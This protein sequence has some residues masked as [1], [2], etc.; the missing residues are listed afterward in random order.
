MHKPIL[1]EDLLKQSKHNKKIQIMKICL[2][3]SLGGHLD[4]MLQL[5]EAFDEDNFF[6]IVQG[7][8]VLKRKPPGIKTYYVKYDYNGIA[9]PKLFIEMLRTLFENLKILFIEKPDVLITTGS[10]YVVAVCYFAKLL[11]KK[12]IFIESLCRVNTLS[13]TGKLLYPISDLFLVQWKSLTKRY[14]KAKYW[15]RVI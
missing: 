5:L 1:M 10:E 6:F 4:E 9:I 12:I 13:G 8:S 11:G 7:E 14:E 15:G 3:C 2:T